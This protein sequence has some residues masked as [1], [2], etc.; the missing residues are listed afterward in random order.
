MHIGKL[1]IAAA[2]SLALVACGSGKDAT[3]MNGDPIA[4]VAA[5]A[6][7]QWTDVVSQT[8]QGYKIG[9][10]DAKLQLVE[11]GA[12]SCPA[13]AAFSV[14]STE[15][16]MAMVNTG[17]VGF[18]F[19]PFLIHGLQDMPGFLL[20]KCNGPEA[21]FPLSEQ[22]YANQESWLSKITTITPAEQQSLAGK[23]ETEV[24]TFL[25][26]KLGLIE[27]VKERGVSEAA[28]KTCLADSVG[29][30]KMVDITAEVGKAGTV[31]GTPSFM[32]NGENIG[33][34]NWAAMKAI[35]KNAGAR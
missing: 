29:L 26:E 32:L 34:K 20:A 16:L 23:K 8:E 6:G 18:E 25:A 30:K 27:F 31:Q 3:K 35:L 2:L 17:T 4:K 22:M 21:F 5:P 24:A 9:N 13:C 19:R 1:I 14:E 12:I 11:Y 33:S 15:E 28:A 10:P 7:K